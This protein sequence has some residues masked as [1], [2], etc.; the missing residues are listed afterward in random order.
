MHYQSGIV[1]KM[2]K[3]ASK[4]F[5]LTYNRIVMTFLQ[6]HQILTFFSVDSHFLC[7]SHFKKSWTTALVNFILV[8]Q[9]QKIA[10]IFT[11]SS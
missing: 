2:W 6:C 5:S 8:S 4:L 3:K 7:G 10:N 1:P 9:Y 11:L